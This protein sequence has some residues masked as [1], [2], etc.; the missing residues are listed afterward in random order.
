[1]SGL[2]KSYGDRTLF[3]G[4]T[5]RLEP[6]DRYGLVGANGSGKTTLLNILAGRDQASLGKLTLSA[7]C[8]IG[9]LHQDR[10]MSDE[11]PIIEVAMMGDELVWELLQEQSRLLGAGEHDT[12]RQAAAIADIEDK[13][14]AADGYTLESRAG[15]VLEGLGIEAETHRQPLS[16]LS[17][18][19]KL[20]VLLAQTLV[21]QPDLL[22]LDEPTNHLDILTIRWL[23]KFFCDYRGCV[24]VISHDHRFLDN[25]ASHILDVDYQTVTL[26]HGNYGAFVEQ[27]QQTRE[28]METEIA[29]VEKEIAHKKSFVERFRYKNT[30]A[31]QAQSRLKQIE[32]L[33][34]PELVQSSRRRPHFR[35]E[36]TRKSGKD[37]LSTEGLHKSYG[38]LHVLTDVSLKVRRNERVGVIG[39]NGLGKSTLLK[40][41]VDRLDA[42]LG[43]LEW[44]HE[45][46]VGYF[47]QNHAEL[48]EDA[49]QTALDYLWSICPQQTTSFVRGQ[50][51]RVLFSGEDVE[52]KLRSLSGGE[53]ARL[54]FSR[55]AVGQPNV[56][57]L[58]EPTNHLDIESIE[59]LVDA[60]LEFEGTLLFVSHDRWFVSQLATRIMEVTASGLHDYPGSYDDY[61]AHCGDDHLDAATVLRKARAENKSSLGDATHKEGN[62]WRDQKKVRARQRKLLA[63]RDRVT[64]AI[65]EAEKRQAEI[66]QRYCEPGFFE[67]TP[68][69]EVSALQAEEA[70]LPPRIEELMA[71]W[72]QVEEELAK[73]G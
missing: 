8:R 2:A 10:Y 46:S 25:V 40:I 73:D 39:A 63:D 32:K 54:I 6:G 52:K 45:T 27:K 29:R 9:V 35:F 31:R 1:M 26:Y 22:L 33:E 16:T 47:P 62:A 48:L 15:T 44:G 41:L 17:G 70:A 59:A 69:D 68:A 30:K 64:A 37:V 61:L 58:D 55:L 13:I 11:Q 23:E 14:L 66:Q 7:G 12:E 20:R 67:Q 57:V 4:V 36:Q 71:A 28:R 19:F 34:I 50:L 53:A 60:L 18:G 65:E 72:E 5:L 43:S 3:E 42:D 51:G 38:D 24:V 56:L 49:N 21:G